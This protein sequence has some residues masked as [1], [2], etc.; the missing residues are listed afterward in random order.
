MIESNP[1]SP[2]PH[3]YGPLQVYARHLIGYSTQP[4]NHQKLAPSALE[5][6]E[7]SMRDPAFYQFYKRIVLLFQKYKKQLN[8]YTYN[9]LVYP[10]V[11]V[12]K[13]EFDRLVTYKEYF[14][15]DVSNALWVTPEEYETGTPTV[16]VGQYR[17]NHKPYTY[18]IHVN[19]EQ[20]GEAVVRVYLGPKYDEYGRVIDINE[21]RINFVELNSFKY[22]LKAGKNVIESD[23]RHTW[24]GSDRT[25]IRSLYDKVETA[26]KNGGELQLDATETSYIAFPA[27]Y[28]LPKGKRGGQVFQVYV[29]VS[30]YTPSSLKQEQQEGNI[31]SPKVGTGGNYIDAMPFGF[32]LDRPIDEYTFYKVPNAYFQDVT[33]YYKDDDV[34]SSVDRDAL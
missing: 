6:F 23:S 5:H 33:I 19:A 1:D 18:K 27:R 31:Y 21:N 2:H 14:E 3:F 28:Q 20:A 12:E 7:T 8:P 24:Y 9:E 15:S 17:L 10:G 11:K 13:V 22:T 34:N 30:K 25:S 16:R 4:Q 32:P 29:M 26:V